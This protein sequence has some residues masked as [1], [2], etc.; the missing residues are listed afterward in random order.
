MSFDYIC[1]SLKDDF[2]LKKIQKTYK[3][4]LIID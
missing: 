4:I 3:M 1:K 2:V